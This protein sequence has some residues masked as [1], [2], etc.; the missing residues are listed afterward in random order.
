MRIL[1]EIRPKQK[2][3]WP[4]RSWNI[5]VPFKYQPSGKGRNRSPPAT[6]HC[7][8]NLNCPMGSNNRFMGTANNFKLNKFFNWSCRFKKNIDDGKKERK[9]EKYGENSGPLTSLLVDCNDTVHANTFKAAMKHFCKTST[10]L[11]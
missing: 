10:R 2:Y 5:D 9:E 7:L 6:S 11:N 1:M 4:T 8:Q 3:F